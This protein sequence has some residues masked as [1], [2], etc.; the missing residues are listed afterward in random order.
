MATTTTTT[1][2][3]PAV[4]QVAAKPMAKGSARFRSS[5]HDE[6]KQSSWSIAHWFFHLLDIDP[7]PPK[8]S[9][10]VADKADKVPYVS[11]W[12]LHRWIALR[13]AVPL[14]LHH[15]L[16]AHYGITLHPVAAFFLYSVAFKLF[17]VS[18]MHMLRRVGAQHGFLDGQVPRDGI[19]DDSVGKV[20]MS[21]ISTS[22]YR[23]VL[24]V[25]LAYDR[26][27]PPALSWMVPAQ[28]TL[29][30]VVLDFWFYWYHRLMHEVPWLWK[31]HSTHHLTRHP[32]AT[33]TLFA[34]EVQEIFD[35]AGIPLFAY[36]TIRYLVPVLG[37]S[38]FGFYEWW[39]C[40]MYVAFIELAGHSGL[41]V[42]AQPPGSF[43]ILR[44]AGI[45][46]CI[47]DHDLHHRR[48]WKKSGNYGKQTRVWDTLFGSK[49][50]REECTE[51][52]VDWSQRVAIP[53]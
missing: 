23:P 6:A 12:S 19:P 49:I 28:L 51:D 21:L 39:F 20:A 10:P 45:E 25:M 42:F 34:D 41:R 13:L 16:V 48:G 38:N 30:T 7:L 26:T 32:N 11:E 37:G 4:P 47:E 9:F 22:T 29:Y 35:I 2:T 53:W 44:S 15:V 3:D 5:W 18:T 31:L 40:G 43:G 14:L 1:A 36:W 8:A 27:A 52:N 24:A 33:L 17:G 46:L 50:P